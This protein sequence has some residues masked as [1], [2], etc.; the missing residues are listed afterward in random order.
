MKKL[1]L[2]FC[3]I[4]LLAVAFFT[5]PSCTK[6]VYEPTKDSIVYVTRY[7]TIK[8]INNN[9]DTVFIGQDS[10]HVGFTYSLD[11]FAK[12]STGSAELVVSSTSTNVPSDATYSWLFDSNSKG[13]FTN[14]TF[15]S[16]ATVLGYN[17]PY[18]GP[19]IITM[20]LTCPDKK[21]VYTVAKTFVLELKP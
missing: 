17:S 15:P 20:I 14:P 5:A 13:A 6:Y 21:K 18:N 8:I 2:S 7:D 3:I 19:H 1:I 11:Y 12:D 4:A 10:I 16:T 9:R